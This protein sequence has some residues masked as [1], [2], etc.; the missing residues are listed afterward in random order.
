MKIVKLVAIQK[1]REA[2]GL[3]CERLAQKSKVSASLIRAMEEGI[4]DTKVM[5]DDLCRVCK[6]LALP[7][8][9]VLRGI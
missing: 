4:E 9:R 3:S 6:S 2:L 7:L 5:F 8:S 1:R